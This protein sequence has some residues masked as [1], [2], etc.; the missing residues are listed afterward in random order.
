MAQIELIE[1]I[2]SETLRKGERLSTV[3]KYM[4]E[5]VELFEKWGITRP[6]DADYQHLEVYYRDTGLKR[7]AA[8]RRRITKRYYDWHVKPQQLMFTDMQ[9][10]TGKEHAM[11]NLEHADAVRGVEGSGTGA[12]VVESISDVSVV[13][14]EAEVAGQGVSTEREA[15]SLDNGKHSRGRK[16]K[17][18]TELRNVKMS[19]YL[20][21][22]VFE[23]IRD[24]AAMQRRDVSNVVFDALADLVAQ[25][26]AKLNAFQ[27]FLAELDSIK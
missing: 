18:Q 27:R 20:T 9:S 17:P 3:T 11:A 8:E 26:S 12:P 4:Q 7:S 6:K 1:R 15:S 22:T 14:S 24:I 2:A 10:E 13:E 23:G 19:I 21:Q 16:P 25:N 5:G